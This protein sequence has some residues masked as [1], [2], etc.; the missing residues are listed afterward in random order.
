[1]CT[2]YF[3]HV[4][5]VSSCPGQ[6]VVPTASLFIILVF[7]YLAETFSMAVGGMLMNTELFNITGHLVLTINAGVTSQHHLPVGLMIVG[8]RFDD[9]TVLAYVRCL[10]QN[11]DIAALNPPRRPVSPGSG[12]G[13]PHYSV[14][15][16]CSSHNIDYITSSL[17]VQ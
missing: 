9:E 13:H 7:T 11:R 2:Q 4:F 1:M 15:S 3:V 6:V 8:K 10:E 14:I 12:C 17:A 5:Q 16:H